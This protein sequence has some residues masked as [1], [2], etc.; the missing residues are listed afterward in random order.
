MLERIQS[1]FEP[2]HT[3]QAVFMFAVDGLGLLETYEAEI[4]IP[5]GILVGVTSAAPLSQTH[6][7]EI[8]GGEESTQGSKES[9][10]MKSTDSNS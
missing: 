7:S 10:P 2:P 1:L 3:F 8:S 4:P 9:P 5:P 6:K